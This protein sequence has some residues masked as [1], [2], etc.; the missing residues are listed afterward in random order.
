MSVFSFYECQLILA[1]L[2]ISNVAQPGLPG[3]VSVREV[4]QR[5]APSSK[6][7]QQCQKQCC[8]YWGSRVPV[9][10]NAIIAHRLNLSFEKALV[11]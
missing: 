7:Q 1:T 8:S 2:I 3:T 4:V 9:C 5:K 11:F 10:S 6:D